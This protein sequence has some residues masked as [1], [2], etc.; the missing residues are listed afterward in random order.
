MPPPPGGTNGARVVSGARR[1]VIAMCS[2]AGCERTA[3]ARTWCLPHYKR[4]QRWGDPTGSKPTALERFWAKV[5][6]DGPG[7]CWIWTSTRNHRG[8]GLFRD[9]PARQVATHRYSYMLHKGEIPEGLFVCHTCD[10][11]PCCNPDHLWLGTHLENMRDRGAKGR[12]R[13]GAMGPMPKAG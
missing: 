10:N 11:P 8:Y 7:G 3:V 5:D 1:S 13:N 9:I 6:K 2:V 12:Y 4:W